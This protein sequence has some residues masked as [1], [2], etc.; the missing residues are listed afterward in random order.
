MSEKHSG[1]SKLLAAELLKT[2]NQTLDN[3]EFR[4]RLENHQD[5]R[6]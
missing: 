5:L 6:Q 2:L 1:L 4:K 3:R